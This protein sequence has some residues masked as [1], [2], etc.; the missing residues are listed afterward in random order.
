MAVFVCGDLLSG[1]IY[2]LN[3]IVHT[4]CNL[5]GSTVS[6]ERRNSS[7]LMN[8]SAVQFTFV[9]KLITHFTNNFQIVGTKTNCHDAIGFFAAAKKRERM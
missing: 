2:T 3:S 4:K 6:A 8:G 1:N 9:M 5:D 7:A